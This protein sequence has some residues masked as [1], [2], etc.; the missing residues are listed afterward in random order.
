MRHV[1]SDD[2]VPPLAQVHLLVRGTGPLV[3]RRGRLACGDALSIAFGRLLCKSRLRFVPLHTDTDVRRVVSPAATALSLF[4]RGSAS[5]ED[6]GAATGEAPGCL[7]AVVL[8]VS[9]ALAALALQWAF[10]CHYDSIDTRKPQSSVSDRTFVP[11]GPRATDKMEWNVGGRSLAGP[12]SRRPD[13]SRVTPWT[14]IFR[15][16][17]SSLTT[18]SDIPLPRFFT[19]SRAQRSSGI[20]KV[21]KLTP[22][23]P[24][25]DRSALTAALNPSA[26]DGTNI[27]FS[28]FSWAIRT[29]GQDA[30]NQARKERVSLT[31]EIKMGI[32]LGRSHAGGQALA[33]WAF[34]VEPSG[35]PLRGPDMSLDMR[36]FGCLH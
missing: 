5:T 30:R 11:S 6:L 12:W 7:S 9:E 24:S 36:L 21:W 18:L 4:P 3:F 26:V 13:R 19:R 1:P 23:F 28:P 34:A 14:R 17:S 35:L 10:L 32:W 22:S 16:S 33:T 29:P 31:P 15:D 20:V 8:R 2:V 25:R 27:N